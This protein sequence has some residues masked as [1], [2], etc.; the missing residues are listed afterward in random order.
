MGVRGGARPGAG[1]RKGSVSGRTRKRVEIAARALNEGKT[2]LEIM[3]E[4]MREAYKAGGPL[5][6]M[7]FAKE[8]A[9]Y[10]HPKLSSVAAKV[11]APTLEQALRML[12]DGRGD[13]A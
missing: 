4:G 3:L 1:R 10:V 8:A 12:V 6:A 9:P 7:P 13:N 11:E 5:A 2:P